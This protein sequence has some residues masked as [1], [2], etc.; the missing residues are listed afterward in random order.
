MNPT[1]YSGMRFAPAQY[2][3]EHQFQGPGLKQIRDALSDHAQKSQ[4]KRTQMRLQQFP[5]RDPLVLFSALWSRGPFD[6]IV[7]CQQCPP[8]ANRVAI[9]PTHKMPGSLLSRT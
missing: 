7:S 8:S 4:R 3:V 9:P 5:D 2:I 1:H 6:G